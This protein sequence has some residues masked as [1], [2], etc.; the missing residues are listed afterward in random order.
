MFPIYKVVGLC[1]TPSYCACNR[2]LTVTAELRLLESLQTAQLT[3]GRWF[4]LGCLEG[5]G[6]PIT[7][8][9][10]GGR[11]H[12]DLRP[13]SYICDLITVKAH[14][15]PVAPRARGSDGELHHSLSSWQ[16]QPPGEGR[17]GRGEGESHSWTRWQGTALG[18]LLNNERSTGLD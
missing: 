4:S 1:M 12:S 14:Q 16:N 11:D 17:K 7:S 9:L 6:L 13:P 5:A 15:E 2:K 10:A 8:T 3:W 18:N